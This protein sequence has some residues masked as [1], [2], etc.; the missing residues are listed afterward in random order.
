M[1]T[2]LED[3]DYTMG[4]LSMQNYRPRASPQAQSYPSKDC[5]ECCNLRQTISSLKTSLSTSEKRQKLLQAQKADL[6]KDLNSFKTTYNS[7][8]RN[9]ENSDFTEVLK[10]KDAEI[11]YLNEELKNTQHLFQELTEEYESFTVN[12]SRISHI[13]DFDDFEISLKD[14]D[15]EIQNLKQALVYSQNMTKK[16]T[17]E[18]ETLQD[19]FSEIQAKT[20]HQE[21][22]HIKS[23]TQDLKEANKKYN[24]LKNKLD[25]SEDQKFSIQN[26]VDENQ[27]LEN[28]LEDLNKKFQEL[29]E[30]STC[31]FK[32]FCKTYDKIQSLE[33]KLTDKDSEIVK[34]RKNYEDCDLARQLELESLK[35]S[36]QLLLSSITK[37]EDKPQNCHKAQKDFVKKNLKMLVRCLVVQE[38][39]LRNGLYKMIENEAGK[40]S[41]VMKNMDEK[42][43]GFR[44][45]F[46]KWVM[47]NEELEQRLIMVE[48]NNLSLIKV[49]KDLQKI[50]AVKDKQFEEV[51]KLYT[52]IGEELQGAITFIRKENDEKQAM[53]I[54][55]LMPFSYKC[56]T[57]ALSA[58]H[59]KYY[60]VTRWT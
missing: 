18:Y 29:E 4:S 45:D 2:P 30:M 34:I 10:K 33:E 16:I 57:E 40:I 15:Q 36:T 5:N 35:K 22:F 20:Y 60:K 50:I 6:Q 9:S 59:I 52:Q 19:K 26:L 21:D 47:R 31:R 44:A 55:D 14:K 48:N 58:A 17:Q 8:K 53:A 13:N 54:Y 46:E 43:S 27:E 3:F 12:V 7:L 49:V 38:R 42:V 41:D 1:S 24:D 32:D 28:A 51:V 56:L 39:N 25:E 23:L 37:N 11:A